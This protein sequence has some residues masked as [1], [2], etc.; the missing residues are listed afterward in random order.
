MNKPVKLILGMASI[1]PIIYIVFFF[2]SIFFSFTSFGTHSAPLP[3][4]PAE[5]FM[6]TG[7]GMPPGF[8][9][10]FGL[11]LFTIVLSIAL[12]IFYI[13]NIFRND[14]VASDK[15]VLWAIVMFFGGMIAMPVYWYIYIWKVPEST[16][17]PV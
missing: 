1:W 5:W 7:P 8:F 4:L 9:I 15:K 17:P 3:G 14:R 10:I 16:A 2:F 12:L 11:H 13:V 6:T